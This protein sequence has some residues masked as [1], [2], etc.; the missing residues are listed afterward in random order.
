MEYVLTKEQ[1]EA[2]RDMIKYLREE[3]YNGGTKA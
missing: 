2:L 1:K 3:Q